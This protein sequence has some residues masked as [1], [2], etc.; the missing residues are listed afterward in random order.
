VSAPQRRSTAS[1]LA[2]YVRDSA[3]P[4]GNG[5]GPKNRDSAAVLAK[6]RAAVL[7]LVPRG[8]Q[9]TT[10]KRP[11]PSAS[12]T[13]PWARRVLTPETPG[14]PG[15]KKHRADPSPRIARRATDHRQRD[16]LPVRP[17]PVQRHGHP[18]TLQAVAARA[19]GDARRGSLGGPNP[20]AHCPGHHHDGGERSSSQPPVSEEG[21]E[22]DR[23]SAKPV[24]NASARG[25][26]TLGGRGRA[27]RGR[28]ESGV[29]RPTAVGIGS[30]RAPHRQ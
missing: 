4:A 19:P 14:P 16:L 7:A 1:I 13:S 15:L 2:T 6:Q 18:R 5:T 10:S 9:L 3:G 11:P 27:P 20:R 17:R 29:V 26:G 12:S 24:R 25:C 28:R 8:S 21:H 23:L 30:F 22:C